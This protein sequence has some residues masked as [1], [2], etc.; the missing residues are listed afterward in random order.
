[1]ATCWVNKQLV[2][3][4]PPSFCSSSFFVDSL[5]LSSNVDLNTNIL[6]TSLDVIPPTLWWTVPGIERALIYSMLYIHDSDSTD[7]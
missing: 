6:D 3:G 1:M 5:L 2:T 4:I 7:Y